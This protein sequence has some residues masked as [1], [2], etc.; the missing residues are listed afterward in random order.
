RRSESIAR[1]EAQ[2]GPEGRATLWLVSFALP[3]TS[4][5]DAKAALDALAR[6][7]EPKFHGFAGS[8]IG[9]VRL[10]AGDVDGALPDLERGGRAMPVL[11]DAISFVHARLHL[12]TAPEPNHDP[13]RA[14]AHAAR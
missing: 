2:A 7:P 6:F 9:H 11:F 12:A 1:L 13:E 10:L 4:A 14:C 5:A 3:A 8:P